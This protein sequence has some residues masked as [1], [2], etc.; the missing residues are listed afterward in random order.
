MNKNIYIFLFKKELIE[1]F[2]NT[3][4]APKHMARDIH[5]RIIDGSHSNYFLS[6]GMLLMRR[7]SDE[8]LSHRGEMSKARQGAKHYLS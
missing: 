5:I 8:I 1:I 4:L 2:C 6:L 7:Y 3:T